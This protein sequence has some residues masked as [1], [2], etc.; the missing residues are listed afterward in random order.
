MKRNQWMQAFGCLIIIV[1]AGCLGLLTSGDSSPNPVNE[2]GTQG[3]PDWD[4]VDQ[5]VFLNLSIGNESDLSGG[6][7]HNTYNIWNSGSTERNI[8]ITV[9]R[10]DEVVLDK[11]I[12]FPPE[13]VLSLRVYNPGVYSVGVNVTEGLKNRTKP[14]DL[15]CTWHEFRV[16][17]LPDGEVLTEHFWLVQGCPS[18]TDGR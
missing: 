4:P 5:T 12:R 11:L 9:W 6:L 2:S 16:V 15:T 1:T 7:E 13:G 17:V 10:G 3:F 8:R 14:Q 18:P